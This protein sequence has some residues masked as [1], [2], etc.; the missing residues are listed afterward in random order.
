[1]LSLF[2]ALPAIVLSLHFTIAAVARLSDALPTLHARTYRKTQLSAAKLYPIVPFKDDIPRHMRYVGAWYLLT[3]AM[4]AWPSTRGSLPTL[5]LVLFWT[6][7]GAWSRAK[8]GLKFRLPLMNAS[9]GVLV[10]VMGRLN[11]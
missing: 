2:A 3:A 11:G 6:G 8:S 10:F 5:G 9:L 4:L 1:M 7:A